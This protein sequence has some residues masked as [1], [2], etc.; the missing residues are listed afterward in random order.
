MSYRFVLPLGVPSELVSQIEVLRGGEP[1]KPVTLAPAELAQLAI[2]E[3]ELVELDEEE[4][5]F[6]PSA[7]PAPMIATIAHEARDCRAGPCD[8]AAMIQRRPL[9][10]QVVAG[11]P[12]FF[13]GPAPTSAATRSSLPRRRSSRPIR[14]SPRMATLSD[15]DAFLK[16]RGHP[17]RIRWA[18]Q[19][20]W[21]RYA[22]EV[23]G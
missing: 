6:G 21:K 16:Q 18:A 14:P 11:P 3:R 22:R 7:G 8:D 12:T 1:L 17:T 20:L 23:R 2:A 19:V 13:A 4:A 5:A 15:V 9:R 10:P